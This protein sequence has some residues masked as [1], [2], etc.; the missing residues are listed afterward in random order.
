M[1]SVFRFNSCT[2]LCRSPSTDIA[3]SLSD[4]VIV[5]AVVVGIASMP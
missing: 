2:T 5:V 3:F 4:I 1:A